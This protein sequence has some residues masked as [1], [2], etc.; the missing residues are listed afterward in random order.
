VEKEEE[1][2]LWPKGR[3]KEKVTRVFA[4]RQVGFKRGPAMKSRDFAA[5]D[6][7]GRAYRWNGE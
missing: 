3:G 6:F 1:E 4:K 2:A 5:T 7:W